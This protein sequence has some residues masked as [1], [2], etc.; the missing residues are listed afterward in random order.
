MGFWY[1]TPGVQMTNYEATASYVYAGGDYRA[2]YSTN[3]NPGGGGP[4]TELTR[5]V[6]YL[7]PDEVIVHDR[8]GTLQA[9]Y[10]KILQWTTLNAPTVTGNSWVATAGSSKLFGA[11]FSSQPLTT[12]ATTGNDN[13][14]TINE[15]HTQNANAA[16][17]VS[18]T[19]ALE[20]AAS[21]TGSMVATT[22]VATTD[23]RMEGVQMGNQVVLFGTNGP[24]LGT[25]VT[26]LSYSITASGATT[27]LLV[28]LTPGQTYQVQVN[29]SVLTSVTAS[30]QG[31]ITFTTT[32]SGTQNVV[33]Q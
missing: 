16:L 25:L 9:S 7:R 20:T 11:T 21:T 13:G 29:G 14:T 32:G 19:T 23:G 26:P 1:G 17:N 18:Y 33:I 15:I 10:A 5:Q 28:D 3:T 4:A 24:V 6:V 12:V 31:T 27:H 2:A 8:V 30:A 22:S